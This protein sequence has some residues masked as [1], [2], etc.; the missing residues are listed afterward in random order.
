MKILSVNIGEKQLIEWN[1]KQVA[2]GIFKK[3]VAT[4]IFVQNEAV[5][6]DTVSDLKN[7]GGTDKAIY[8]Y[9]YANYAYFS[10][11]YPKIKM[12]YG[13]FGENIT[14]E[15][16][17]ENQVQIGDTFQIGT[18]ILQV[19]QP[20]F[21]CYKLGIVFNNQKILKDF[22]NSPH[23]GFYF[24][25]LQAG[26]IAK[27]NQVKLIKEATNSMSVADVFSLYSHNKHN[28]TMIQ[29]ALK[30]E[31]LA[32]DWKKRMERKLLQN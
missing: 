26:N 7:H 28:K 6:N 15:N 13:V 21:P 16:L 29:K 22:L 32:K 9:S 12:N 24:R 10:K 19:T 20:R 2:T 3:P 30:L 27:N 14:F 4:S 18:T 17:D 31:F 8:G 25:V 5:A 11:L 1:N 23:C